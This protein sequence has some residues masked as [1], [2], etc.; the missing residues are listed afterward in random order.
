MPFIDITGQRF[1]RLI[2]IERA[3]QVRRKTWV[4]RCDCGAV[5]S[6]AASALT[7]RLTRSCGCLNQEQ[8]RA[9]SIDVSGQRFG[10]LV[11]LSLYPAKTGPR[12]WLCRC[13]CGK[14]TI[15]RSEL[16]RDGRTR[17]CGCLRRD[18][19]RKIKTKHGHGQQHNQSPTYWS[20]TGMLARCRN[21]KRAN[22]GGRGI[23]VCERWHTFEHFLADMGERPPGLTLDRINNDGPYSPE[24]CRWATPK[25]QAANS[26]PKKPRSTTSL[27]G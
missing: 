9:R 1:G 22:Y 18:V 15:V 23:N 11:A 6:V 20:W 21:I 16:L 2:V 17:S 25:E 26:R 5:K 7:A 10:R 24:N 19:L 27:S 12:K 13:D 8:R 14:E 4:C 3:A